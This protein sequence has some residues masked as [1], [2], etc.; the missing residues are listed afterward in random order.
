MREGGTARSWMAVAGIV[1]VA[2]GLL[3]FI[4]NPLVGR[5][6]SLVPTDAVHNIVHLATGALALYIAFGLRGERQVNATIGFGVLYLVIFLAVLVSPNLF[7]LFQVRANEVLH[8]IHVALAVV[9]LAVGFMARGRTPA[10][11]S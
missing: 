3:G 10:Y 9:S 1:L 8:L 5:A 7:G 4:P 2:V 11:A 6:D